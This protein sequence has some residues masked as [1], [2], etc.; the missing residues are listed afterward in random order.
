MVAVLGLL[1]GCTGPP[2]LTGGPDA[3]AAGSPLLW[4]VARGP[5]VSHLFGTV[6]MGRSL[7]DAL[8]AAGHA[9]LADADTVVVELDLD[10]P[11]TA[12]AVRDVIARR[13]LLPSEQSLERLVAPATWRWL[14][15]ALAAS[16]PE[17]QLAQLQPWLVVYL[18]IG[19]RAAVALAPAETDGALA[20]P[21]DL[22]L[23]RRVHADGRPL[24]PLETAAEQIEALA[25]VPEPDAVAL[26]DEIARD[27]EALDRQVRGV[28]DG[29]RR[30][31]GV[32]HV[33]RMVAAAAAEA[34]V[35]AEV[36]FF[37]RTERWVPRLLPLLESGG[38]FVAVGAGHLVGERGLVALLR[39]RGFD[40]RRIDAAGL[41]YGARPPDVE[42]T[43]CGGA[44]DA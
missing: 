19:Q 17:A 4:R 28:V 23:A 36:L 43:T 21:M 3:A 13:G 18:A 2:R 27:P 44:A 39:A 30:A 14:T 34:P 37:A 31:D 15:T 38:A 5:A 42:V 1:G 26:L 16:M 20:T 24:V 9:A 6:H 41:V 12:L 11:E 35:M 33:E 8:G 22:A 32:A 7:D 29:T 10:A 40:V 25:A